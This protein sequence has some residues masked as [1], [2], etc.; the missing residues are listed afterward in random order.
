M[1]GRDVHRF[2]LWKPEVNKHWGEPELDG[3]VI[4]R[5]IEVTDVHRFLEGIPEGKRP[6]GRP[7]LRWEDEIKMDRWQRCAQNSGGET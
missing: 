6:L 3:R 5:W 4:L 2:L 7:R 1:E